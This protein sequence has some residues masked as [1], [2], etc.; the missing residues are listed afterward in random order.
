MDY[1]QEG[2]GVYGGPEEE[3]IAGP[4]EREALKMAGWK[5]TRLRTLW[6]PPAH[7]GG[8]LRSVDEAL[9]LVASR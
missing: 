3:R 2:P 9:D 4:V 1:E 5:E 8:S 7:I 6:I